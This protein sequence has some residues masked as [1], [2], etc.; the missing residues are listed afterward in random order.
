[1]TI[2][3]LTA[4]LVQFVMI[5]L[6]R[7]R[8][9]KH[10]LRRPVTLL[11]LASVIELGIGPALLAVPAIGANDTDRFGIQPGF[12]DS[13]DLIMSVSMLALTLTYLLTH[14]ERT[15]TLEQTT[16]LMIAARA[17][18][19]RLL[20]VACIP[21]TVLTAAG[22]G[23]NNGAGAGPATSLTTNLVTTFFVVVVVVAAAAFLMRHGTRWFLLVLIIQSVVLAVA[24]E[25]TPVLMDATA[26]IVMLLFAGLRVPV[27]QLAATAILTVLILLSLSGIRAEQ[28][29]NLYYQDSGVSTRVSALAGGLSA[30]EGPQGGTD[31]PGL[32]T[33]FAVR[34]SA[35][36][37]GGAILQAIS[38]GQPRLSPAY[39]PESL[40][41]AVP[42]FVWPTKLNRTVAL[43]PALAQIN[44]FGLQDTNF[45][46]GL[47]GLYIGFL[48][49][50]W[51]IALFGLFGAIF[52]WFERWL[53]RERTPARLVLLGG[54]VTV[55]LGLE[56][57]LPGM[58]V[59]M[60]AAV[61]LA[62]VVYVV[63]VVRGRARPTN[64][65]FSRAAP[66]QAAMPRLT[67]T[68]G[69][70]GIGR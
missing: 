55:A 61:A 31:T 50:T 49:P 12:I 32:L 25:R 37:Y 36:D 41:L 65:R 43:D 64:S 14:P 39:V 42:S 51:L 11:V 22:R 2:T 29:R 38:E 15:V 52:G 44:A 62:L 21:L 17:L 35:V 20:A 18:D 58:L 24:G 16:D 60:R 28:N 1:V 27:P 7:H 13:A 68:H 69:S 67:A 6:L 4:L 34:I 45:I 57:G 56:A 10:W 5:V 59:Q 30:A 47:P 54:A 23:Y 70:Q 3:F 33:Q 26:L 53:L 9:G 63:E 8:L 46:P 48:T 19:W 40:L 66:G